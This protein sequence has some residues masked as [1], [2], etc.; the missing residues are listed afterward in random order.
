MAFCVGRHRRSALRAPTPQAGEG[1][2]LHPLL[3]IAYS[4]GMDDDKKNTG[5]LA[6]LRVLDLS[7]VLAGPSCTQLLGDLG[8]DV[9]KVE[10]PGEG[11]DTRLWGPP[12]LQDDA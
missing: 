5:P 7:R 10:K 3:L 8:A 2:L 1:Q 6:G 4:R 12:Y 11:D 9:V